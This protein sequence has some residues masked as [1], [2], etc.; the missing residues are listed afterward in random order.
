M[1][2]IT[3][4]YQSQKNEV[5]SNLNLIFCSLGVN[6]K[7]I[8]ILNGSINY[9]GNTQYFIDRLISKLP[10]N[11]YKITTFFSEDYQQNLKYTAL[12]DPSYAIKVPNDNIYELQKA[13]LESDLFIIASPVYMH[14][15]SSSLK[16]VVEKLSTW[17]HIMRL[18]GM[19]TVVLSTCSS[20]GDTTVTSYLCKIISNMGG[21]IVANC[22]ANSIQ[23][24]T[25]EWLNEALG[26]LATI[27]NASIEQPRQSNE[28]VEK[29]FQAMKRI[30]ISRIDYDK[31]NTFFSE[32]SNY[33]KSKLIGFDS[34]QDYLKIKES[35][36]S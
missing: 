27:I 10:K 23:L 31:P 22:N 21:N 33:W 12:Y 20:N 32:E 17:A 1:L 9:K 7:K 8:T 28:Y 19:P 18:D 25:D 5:E 14:N 3:G 34:Y 29:V 15:I 4:N 24:N 16:L 6:M 26:K 13:I 11:R 30:M 2:D 35:K 36:S